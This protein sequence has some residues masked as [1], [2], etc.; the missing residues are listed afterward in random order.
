VT[1][2]NSLYYGDNLDVLRRYVKDE[3]VDLVYLDP[4]FNS[5]QDYNVLFG[6]QNGAR[7]AAQIKAF[8]DTWRWDEGAARAYQEVVEAGGNVSLALQAFRTFLGETDMLAYL[9]MMAPR[10][11]EL[12]RVL[13]PTGAIYL[14]CDH[15]ASHYLKM[16]M[17]AI[18]GARSFKNNI[19]WKRTT[20]KSDFRQGA[21]NWA[22]VQDVLLY[23]V[24]DNEKAIFRQPFGP[25]T[26]D[27]YRQSDPD[28]RRYQ[29]T[30]LNA[31]GAG[32]RGHPQ[33]E[34]MGVTRYWRYSEKK[35]NVLLAEGRIIQPSPG[36]VPRYKRYLDEMSGVPIGDI[37]DDVTPINS[38]A[39][40]RLGYPTQKPQA[41]LERIIAASTNEGDTVLDPFC[42][43][44]TTVA[45]AQALK[46]RWIGIDI[47]HLAIGLI[48]I[49]L[50]DSFGPDVAETYS[51]IGEPVSV[52]DAETLA[53]EDPY[54]FQWWTLG[55]V[56]ARPVD[57]KKGAD[58]GIDGRLFFHD[59]RSGET[60]Q[61][62]F[63]VKAGQL[64]ATYVRDLRGVV[65]RER[66]EIGV[67]ISMEDPTRP[68]RAEAASAGFYTSPWGEHPRIQLRTVAELLAGKGVDYPPTK[69]DSTFKKAPRAT[70]DEP[71]NQELPLDMVAERPK[72]PRRPRRQK[73]SD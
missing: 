32:S 20:P 49:R 2:R 52:P 24:K 40:E 46:R 66:A 8:E 21:T 4:P 5:N 25:Y 12:R 14:H 23:Y 54:Q 36:A 1:E 15:T 58:K 47:T 11:I 48:K 10:L 26:V 68:M 55:L 62:V 65:E 44:G 38:Q 31:P 3:T 41:L 16:L 57:K 39:Q 29:L 69:A 59:E 28:G 43:C 53:A 17:D 72:L 34:F 45:A 61:I 30:A 27:K 33:Y 35:M 64:H 9:A 37:W 18:F 71:T 63:S 19:V 70:Y 73:N 7:A 42:G 13:K 50:K 51:V 22:R 67:L 60:K 6:E 56:G